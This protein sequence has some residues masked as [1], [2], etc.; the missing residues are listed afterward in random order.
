MKEIGAYWN[1][2]KVQFNHGLHMLKV[3]DKKRGN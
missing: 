2:N 1:K 3:L